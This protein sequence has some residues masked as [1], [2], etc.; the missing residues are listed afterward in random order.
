[1]RYRFRAVERFWTCFY[2]AI[3]KAVAQFQ[4]RFLL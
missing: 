4:S 3:G 2:H 1:M